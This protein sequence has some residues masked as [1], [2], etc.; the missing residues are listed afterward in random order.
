MD[1]RS[2]CPAPLAPVLRG[3]GLGVRGD[4]LSAFIRMRLPSTVGGGSPLTPDPSPRSTGA[5]GE[6][7]SASPHCELGSSGTIQPGA[8]PPADPAADFA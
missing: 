4:S 3:E 1:S 8:F 7:C 6:T 5:R 2:E